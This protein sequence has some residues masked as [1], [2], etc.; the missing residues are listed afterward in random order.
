MLTQK[1]LI[2]HKPFIMQDG[3]SKL[4]NYY[5]KSMNNNASENLILLHSCYRYVSVISSPELRNNSSNL[6]W[7]FSFYVN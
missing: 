1:L 3:V 5:R 4:F 7:R 2:S 6:Y